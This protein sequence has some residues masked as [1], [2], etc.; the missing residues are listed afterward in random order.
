MELKI[1]EFPKRNLCVYKDQSRLYY[2]TVKFKFGRRKTTEIFDNEN[3]KLFQVEYFNGFF[4]E[5]FKIISQNENLIAKIQTIENSK[6]VLENSSILER[7]SSFFNI[8]NSK[9]SYFYNEQK[10]GSSKVINW[11]NTQK[12]KLNIKEDKKGVLDLLIILILS[13]ES[14]YS[15]D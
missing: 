6:I 12:Y 3:N 7:K 15:T 9:F 2:S 5:T 10:I 1:I 13:N 14:G 8:T 4:S 11:V